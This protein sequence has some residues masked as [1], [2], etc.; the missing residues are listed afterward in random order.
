[1]TARNTLKK[2]DN[3]F[4]STFKR[5]PFMLVVLL[6]SISFLLFLNKYMFGSEAEQY[7]NDLPGGIDKFIFSLNFCVFYGIFVIMTIMSFYCEMISAKL[8]TMGIAL[9]VVPLSGYC[10]S[11]LLTIKLTGYLGWLITAGVQFPVPVNIPIMLIGSVYMAFFQY[12]YRFMGAADI[13]FI[14]LDPEIEE[15]ITFFM[16]VLILTTIISLSHVFFTNWQRKIATNQHLNRVMNQ[17]CAF[18][19]GLQEAASRS[20]E[21]ASEQE[22]LR[23]T[24]EIHDSAGYVFVNIIALMDAVMSGGCQN[25]SEE[26]FETIKKQASDGLKETRQVLHQLREVEEKTPT[27][28]DAVYKLKD[29]F[30]DVTG[31]KV[32]IETGNI[33]KEYG[34]DITYVI[35]RIVQESF[36]NSVRHGHATHILIHFWEFPGK[37]TMTVTDNGR[38]AKSIVKGIG[39]AGMEERL[40][41]VNG[42]LE[43]SSPEE[44]GFRLQISIPINQEIEYGK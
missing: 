20:E 22:R 27:T 19:R 26:L 31:I 35:T 21:R 32:Q 30:E 43:A 17:M 42:T 41:K 3:Y 40:A 2:I 38:G 18:N 6:L 10:F 11:D 13:W 28:I 14:R 33:Q 9:I 8:I 12:H 15:I 5:L 23:I 29:I 39:L 7:M 4:L 1:M 37:M 44:G 25:Q 16:I 34:P 24:R 36:T